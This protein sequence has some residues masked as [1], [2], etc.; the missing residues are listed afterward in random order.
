MLEADHMFLGDMLTLI[1]FHNL[2]RELY[3]PQAYAF[4]SIVCA[5]GRYW[6]QRESRLKTGD[7]SV[8]EMNEKINLALNPVRLDFS[9]IFGSGNPMPQTA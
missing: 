7:E 3:T 5:M 2:P 8:K 6:W 4:Y 1:E 9:H